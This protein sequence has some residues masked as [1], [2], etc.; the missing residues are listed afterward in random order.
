MSQPHIAF[1]ITAAGMTWHYECHNHY[2][3]NT[4]LFI[5][6]IITTTIV[7]RVP[8]AQITSQMQRV[9]ARGCERRSA[10]SRHLATPPVPRPIY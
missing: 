1:V 10:L 9:A 8:G 2:F 6:I 7:K 3:I 5:I 4:I